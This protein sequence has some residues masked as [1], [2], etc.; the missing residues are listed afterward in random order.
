MNNKTLFQLS[1]VV[2]L[3]FSVLFLNGYVFKWESTLFGVFQELLTILMLVLQLVLLVMAFKRC[4]K[5]RFSTKSLS[6]WSFSLLMV[7]SLATFGSLI[8]L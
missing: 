6:L 7:S 8:V 3:Y 4:L 2:F 1:L 5:D